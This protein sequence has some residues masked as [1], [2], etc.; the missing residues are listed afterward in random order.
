MLRIRTHR[1]VVKPAALALLSVSQ[2]GGDKKALGVPGHFA[3]AALHNLHLRNNEGRRQLFFHSL[4]LLVKLV[5]AGQGDLGVGG[6]ANLLGG[7]L[8]LQSLQ[9]IV[10]H[11]IDPIPLGVECVGNRNVHLGGHLIEEDA[12]HVQLLGSRQVLP[13][14]LGGEDQDRSHQPGQRGQDVV[15]GGLSRPAQD[16]V[17]LLAVQPVLDDIQIEA[18]H[19][20]HAEVVDGVEGDV[21]IQSIISRPCLIVQLVQ[22]LISPLVQLCQLI[23]G[24]PVGVGIEA[25]QVTQDIPGG[26]PDLPVRL[27][28]LLQ[29]VVGKPDVGVI[30][31]RS[32]PQTENVGAVLVDDLVGGDGVT[33]G[34][35]HGT[36]LA[37]H[38]PAV[39]AD[40]LVRR[41]S[42]GSHRSEKAG[43]EPAPVLVSA[44]QI[45]VCRPFQLRTLLQNGGMGDAGVEPHV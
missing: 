43:L 37:V 9:H 1:V 36:A 2:R 25:V 17:P 42:G 18:G 29:N 20:H 19:F 6:L 23:G 24:D 22:P 33:E 35:V 14:L 4:Q 41:L 44:L 7:P 15:H 38:D 32:H 13:D 11:P 40:C 21:I 26:V 30:V 39:S 16:A 12:L 34:F 10:P 5:A 27:R 3:F 28:Q 8:G 45:E 31:G